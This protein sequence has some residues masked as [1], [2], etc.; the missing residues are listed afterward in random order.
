MKPV[1][2]IRSAQEIHIYEKLPVP[3]AIFQLE[4]DA[5]RLQIVSDGLVQ[6]LP[7]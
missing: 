5:I 6:A 1:F 4:G 3:F 2:K 7:D